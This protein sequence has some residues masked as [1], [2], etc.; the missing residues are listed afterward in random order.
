MTARFA[1]FLL[2]QGSICAQVLQVGSATT[3]AGTTTQIPITL[4]S[5]TGTAPSALE[6]NLV[7]G[8]GITSYN[9]AAGASATSGGKTLTCSGAT[10]ILD[11]MNETAIPNG[12]VAT[13]TVT[14]ASGV[15]QNIA[16]QLGSVMAS[17]P[18]GETAAITA[19]PGTISI[20][21]P[22]SVTLQPGAVSLAA[23]ATQQFTA[24]VT[25][26]TAGNAAVTWSLSPNVGTI[27]SSGLYTAPAAISS[28]QA[29][30]VTATSVAS[31]TKSASAA[32]TLNAPVVVSMNPA[33]ASLSAGQSQQFT[34]TVTG[35]ANSAVT[36][37]LSPGI[38]TISSTGLY[39]APATVSSQ[40]VVTVTATS[41]A[42]STKSASAAITLGTPVVVSMNPGS[43]SLSAGQSQQFTATVTGAANSAVT[44]S[45]TPNVG[46][47]SN[48]GL[49]TAP[50]AVASQQTVTVTAASVANS[51]KSASANLTLSAGSV[52]LEIQ[53]SQ[54]EVTGLTNGSI[55]VPALGPTGLIGN[56]VVNGSGSVNF[57][58][59]SANGVS[60]LNCCNNTNN[61]YY[62]LSGAS[63]GSIFEMAQG[64]IS[65]SLTS[66]YSFAQRKAAAAASRYVFDAR[67]GNGNHLFAFMTQVVSGSLQFSATPGGAY[68]V[69]AG[70]EDGLFG[71]GVTLNVTI[72]WGPTGT[73][74]ALNNRVVQ[75]G[76]YTTPSSNW[77]A[78]STFLL[79]A[80]NY[81]NFGGY[82]SS[83]D[84][85]ANF[86]VTGPAFTNMPV[87]V[88]IVPATMTL[89]G[90]QSQQF[91]AAVTGGNSNKTVTWS[92]TPSLGAITN[93][94]MYTAPVTFTAGET[95]SITATSTA[96]A[97][98]SAAANVSLASSVFLL[99]GKASE[100]SG[101]TN[102]SAVTPS[103]A[104]SGF[105]GSVAANGSGSVNFDPV[106]N[107]DGVYFLN[108][109]VNTNNAYFKF[110]GSDVGSIFG[111]AQGSITFS[112]TSRYSFAQRK[113]NPSQQ[114][115]AFDVRD[116]NGNHLF[117]F[118]TEVGSGYLQFIYWP[119]AYYFVPAGTEDTLFGNGV[120][121]NVGISWANGTAKLYLNGQLVA[122]TKS[123]S[124]AANWTA[125]SNF[126]LG[127][128]EYLTYGG[129]DGLDDIISEFSV[130]N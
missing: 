85:I 28:Q 117:G 110:T 60:F 107:G 22:V 67:D 120:T 47:I 30:T 21:G 6:W 121:L 12:T 94:G 15:T 45:V 114:R 56:V 34:A 17:A 3:Q 97:T 123:T 99:H 36:W 42:N 11:G 101:V 27:S 96:D 108:C 7:V 81:E 50:A 88:S 79:G 95:V 78:A 100:V 86:R 129:Y 40:Q 8:S 19:Q 106:N 18:N 26:G 29:V 49:Y 16:M 119:G 125:A 5:G 31:P 61:A 115:Y 130:F 116:G 89:N 71:S 52:L 33:T 10:C 82:D 118:M 102:G 84:I 126:D 87:G 75:S 4:N 109:C 77:T 51:T 41:A 83:D 64:Q 39:T 54:A 38:G 57:A 48:T 98:K 65:F 58:S 46:T 103:L 93:N 35:T 105:K 76:P 2:V 122:S 70:T 73:T 53:G 128:Y 91:L 1:L 32:I 20:A 63:V 24:T 25:G 104:P 13:V 80:Y 55:F 113:A 127:A 124:P 43:A 9:V 92:V 59:A 69:P 72:A 14:V 112:L 66:R 44:W 74:L 62:Q 23:G 68:T 111:S 37:S 90:G